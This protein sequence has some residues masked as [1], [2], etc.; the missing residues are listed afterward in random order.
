MI[1]PNIGTRLENHGASQGHSERGTATL[2]AVLIL[3]LL[4]L[5][6]AAS[7]TRTTNEA[8]VA[9]NDYS[10][11]QAFYAAQASLELMSRNFG[12]VFT[13]RLNPT[14]GDIDSIKTRTPGLNGFNFNQDIQQ[15]DISKT[16][17]IEEG[18]FAGL[19]SL[20][21]PWVAS[22]T[23]TYG[24]GAEVQLTRTFFNNRIPIFQFGIFYNDDM[25][26]HPGP[27]FDFGGRV[28][29]NGN[30][31]MQASTG[32]YFRSRVTAAGEIVHD[33]ARNGSPY[34]NWGDNVW[35]AAPGQ[36]NPATFP[37]VTQGSVTGGPDIN[38]SD[39]DMPNGSKNTN[40]DTFDMRFGGNLLARQRQL[41]LPLQINTNNDP[42]LL[43]E[44]GLPTD[45]AILTT[46][47][48][49][50]K[51]CLRISLND[52]QS[53]LPGGTGGVRL[54]GAADG[55]GGD[56]AGAPRG[57]RPKPMGAYQA[58]RINAHR[59]YTGASYTDAGMPANRQ[60]WI[61]VEI[62]T[63]DPSSLLPLATDITEDFCALGLTRRDVGGLDIGDDRSVLNLQQYEIKGPPVRVADVNGASNSATFT[64][65][66]ANC[67]P[68]PLPAVLPNQNY[69]TYD[70]SRLLS[71]VAVGCAANDNYSRDADERN[72][73]SIVTRTVNG[74]S[75]ALVPFPIEMVDVREGVFFDDLTAAQWNSAAFYGATGVP[76]AG[77]MSCLDFN[78]ANFKRLADGVFDAEFPSG[79]AI[80]AMIRD[81]GGWIVY[82]SDRR[83]DRNN[84]GRYDME[85]VYGPV[86][87]PNDGILQKGED[88]NNNGALD[89]DLV[90]E[91]PPYSGGTPVLGGDG[92]SRVPAAVPS[93]VAAVFD[94]RYYRRAVRLI[95]GSLLP[96]TQT[97][98]FTFSSENG[99]YVIGNY[100]ATGIAAVG[101]PSQPADYTGPQSPASIVSDSITVL[102]NQWNDGK[103][104][105]RPYTFSTGA[106][107]GDYFTAR[108]VS[109]AGETAVRA[110]FLMGDTRSFLYLA[111]DPF[112]GGGDPHMSGGV[113]NFPRFMED[114]A[115]TRLN[116]CGSLINLFNSNNNNGPFKC[117]NHIYTPPTRNWVFDSSFYDPNRLPPGTPFFQY[118]QMSG[119]RQTTRQ[120]K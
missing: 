41:L 24:T 90:W 109:A 71:C 28:H 49:Y 34:T 25:E 3:G 68:P 12:Q 46:S 83:G 59:L 75:K 107:A 30:I 99:V 64:N 104:F 112:Q 43:V 82:V 111:G 91:A 33:V 92:V 102:S 118:V 77:N 62:V 45:D 76:A 94:H 35:V 84:N 18:P 44:R 106:V 17:T 27:R 103:S 54:D 22:A 108:R 100:N 72:H 48:Y 5:F 6:T 120:V 89:R 113:H 55:L 80:G 93:D 20:R 85:D 70:T 117:C 38:S 29:S 115:G 86:A 19:I 79:R 32:L 50:N 16:E 114:W 56:G 97:Y 8:T 88:T 4:A 65:R 7:L 15:T 47:R 36:T 66:Q 74:V 53:R 39:P 9:G 14:P 60:T 87:N 58:T 52:S 119:F 11:T 40:W 73:D 78:V 63:I 116:Y 95:N 42:I 31:F 13:L 69:Y 57:Y 98:G 23:A 37:K 110:A 10:N 26:F 105:R 81:P 101:T 21:D 1:N 96:G 67:P 2:T 51:P 61:K